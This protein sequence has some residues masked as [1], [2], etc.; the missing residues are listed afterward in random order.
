MSQLIP[1]NF[2]E[3]TNGKPQSQVPLGL[4]LG[5]WL[6]LSRQ[7]SVVSVPMDLASARVVAERVVDRRWLSWPLS[8]RPLLDLLS[9]CS[10]N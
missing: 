5:T 8:L 6:S 7:G 9:V 2:S 3:W 1:P 10:A 4:S